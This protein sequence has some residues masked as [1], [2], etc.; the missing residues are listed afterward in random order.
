MNPRPLGY[1]PYDAR[2]CRL[3]Q[4]PAIALTSPNDQRASVLS[5]RVSPVSE[6]PATSRAQIRAQIWLLTCGFFRLS[7]AHGPVGLPWVRA[8]SFLG[9]TLR[10]PKTSSVGLLRNSADVRQARS[11]CLRCCPGVT[12]TALGRPP[13]R[14]REGHGQHLQIHSLVSDPDDRHADHLGLDAALRAVEPPGD[15]RPRERT[16]GFQERRWFTIRRRCYLRCWRSRLARQAR[17]S[18][19]YPASGL[20]RLVGRELRITSVSCALLAGFKARASS[21]FAGCCWWRPLAVDGG[22]GGISG[23]RPYCVGQVPP[24][25]GPGAPPL[26]PIG[27]TAADPFAGGKVSR[28]DSRVR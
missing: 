7:K 26:S 13:H 10:L 6:R 24:G 5:L 20:P 17:S 21:K 27:L 18:R 2:L 15:D 4:S 22:S 23:A 16:N 19:V 12:E 28:A 3:G 11:R 8:R 25:R 1:E 14:A 9:W